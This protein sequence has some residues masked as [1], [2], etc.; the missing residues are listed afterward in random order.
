MFYNIIMN[1]LKIL[2]FSVIIGLTAAV[3]AVNAWTNP[4][5]NPPSGSAALNYY[6]GNVGIGTTGP[7]ALFSIV[8]GNDNTNFQQNGKMQITAP[9]NRPDLT[10]AGTI[11]VESN[12]AMGID[13]VLP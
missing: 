1:K 13:K 5:A 8:S 3:I 4:S 7:R 11:V 10:G 9:S 2:F 12:D 6:N